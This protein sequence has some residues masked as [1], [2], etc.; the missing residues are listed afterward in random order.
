MQQLRQMLINDPTSIGPLLQ[1]LQQ[2]SPE[3]YDVNILP[4]E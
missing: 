3:L 2:T 1:Q 4:Y